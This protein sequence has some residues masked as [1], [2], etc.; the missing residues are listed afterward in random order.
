MSDTPDTVFVRG[1]GGGIIEM[2]VPT[3]GH[4]L[5][6][7]EEAIRKGDLTLV[8][9]AHWVDRAD[10]SKYLVEGEAPKAAAKSGKAKA[11]PADEPTTSTED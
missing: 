11:E 7:Y 10:G 9:A 1:A 3:R 6:R 2:D 8:G 4:A 5:E